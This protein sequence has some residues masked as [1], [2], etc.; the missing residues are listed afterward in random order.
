MSFVKE[1]QSFLEGT[2]VPAGMNLDDQI[3]LTDQNDLKMSDKMDQM[4]SG[5]IIVMDEPEGAAL[6]NVSLE[7]GEDPSGEIVLTLDHVP[8]GLNQEEIEEPAEIEVE[9]PQEIEIDD[10]PWAWKISNFLPWLSKMMKAVPA[11]SGRDTAG[12]ERA[13]AYLEEL[14]RHIS[15]AMRGDLNNELSIEAIEKARDEIQR[16]I[17]RLQERHEKVKSSK[18]PKKKKKKS[19]D[20]TDAMIKTAGT[21][22]INGISITVPLWIASLAKSCINGMVS[23]GKDIEKVFISLAEEY[24]LDKRDKLQLLQLLDDMNYPVR[25][26]LGMPLD[27]PIDTTSVDNVNWLPNYDA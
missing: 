20:E 5:D 15:R 16:G 11:H 24:G 19:E 4:H 7:V 21:P 25:R 9:E 2:D 14:D 17:E 8:G 18:Y 26:D 12:L 23:S 22:R 10:D 1:S 6:E 27:K 3:D 13:V